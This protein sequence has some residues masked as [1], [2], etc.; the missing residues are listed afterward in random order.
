MILRTNR[1]NPSA[2]TLVEVMVAV[3]ILMVCMVSVLLLVNQSLKLVKEM[4]KQRPDLGALAGKTL[5]DPV[6][7]NEES[8]SINVLEIGTVQP[9]DEDFELSQGGGALSIYRNSY[10]ERDITEVDATNG[11]YRVTVVVT[12]NNSRG[13]AETRLNFLMFRPDFA[14]YLQGQQPG[15]GQ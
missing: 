8:P 2:F 7:P 4:Q 14:K 3:A 6:Q 1:L 11:L 10:W 12:E 15:G 9:F 5:M 13:G